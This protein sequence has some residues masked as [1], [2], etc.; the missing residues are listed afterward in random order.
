MAGKTAAVSVVTAADRLVF[1]LFLALAAHSAFIL[2]TDAPALTAPRQTPTSIEVTL[3]QERLED[4]PQQAEFLAK[5]NQTGSGA[6]EETSFTFGSF[7]QSRPKP[8]GIQS[9]VRQMPYVQEERGSLTQSLPET[10]D[11]S[12]EIARLQALLQQQQ[13]RYAKRLRIKRLTSVS[14]RSSEDASY[15][16]AWR[17][18][19]ESIGNLNYP[20]E[21]NRRKLH[22]NLR[23][24]VAILPDGSLKNVQI[25]KTS[26]HKV[27]D[28]AALDI[29]RLA[30]PFA[31]FPEELRSTTDLLEIIRTW[32]F[33]KNS[34]ARL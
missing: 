33:R 22:G 25:L 27:L 6:A 2:G 29:V 7:Y 8:P 3:V 34:V 11:P 15:V 31:P 4:A 23:L 14:A 20:E 24:M 1:T 26:G 16:D 32:E 21:A 19:V 9:S 5:Y 13:E 18:R 17:R 12:A 28:E 30:T 10:G